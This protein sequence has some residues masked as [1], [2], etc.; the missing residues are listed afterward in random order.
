LEVSQSSAQDLF[1]LIIQIDV[2]S[3]LFC[4]HPNLILLIP[5]AFARLNIDQ[6]NNLN[7][8]LKVLSVPITNIERPA[9]FRRHD[10]GYRVWVDIFAL[11]NM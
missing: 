10:S 2:I 4:P 9:Q 11:A 5:S 3:L 6:R 7:L 1:I 8:M